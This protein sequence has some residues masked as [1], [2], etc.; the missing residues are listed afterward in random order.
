MIEGSSSDVNKAWR[1]ESL[2]VKVKDYHRR[3][4]TSTIKLKLYKYESWVFKGYDLISN[5]LAL[6]C[7]KNR[8]KEQQLNTVWFQSTLGLRPVPKL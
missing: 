7:V 8:Y 1:L 2:K 4:R 6:P 5:L 3:S